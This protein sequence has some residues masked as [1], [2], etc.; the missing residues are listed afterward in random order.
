MAS[1]G[2]GTIETA[3]EAGLVFAFRARCVAIAVVAVVLLIG[4][5]WPRN[6][7]YLSFAAG[8]FAFGYVPFLLRRTR[9]AEAIKLAFVV[10]DVALITAAVLN[11]PAS[12][13]SV[14][15]PIQTR[16]KN[17]NFLLLLVLLGEAAITY[18]A[19]RVAW[20]GASIVAVWGASFA[21]VYGLPDTK[22]FGEITAQRTDEALLDVFLDP[23][24]VSLPSFVTQV[25]ATVFL[26]ALVASA[27]A[28][29][30]R[31][32]VAQVR[33][34]R[35]RSDL[36]RYVSP[37]V[38]EALSRRPS[39]EFGAPANRK[40]A[41]LF[42]DIV[43]FTRFNE[44]LSP[45]RTFALLRGFQD[46][47]TQAV[48]RHGGTLDKYLGDGFMATFGSLGDEPDAAARAIA[49]AFDLLTEVEAWNAERGGGPADRL[50]VAIGLHY[51]TAVVG[52]LGSENRLEFTAVG[53]VVNVASRLEE[54]TRELG[55][56]LAISD[57]CVQ[58]AG[59]LDRPDRLGRTVELRLRGRDAPLRVHVA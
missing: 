32:L 40:V 51:G 45:E 58:A 17:Q 47:S 27:V 38:A 2:S 21:Y 39:A 52:N 16:L 36:A 7:Y 31:H 59:A 33:A 35:L 29:S 56:A 15:W 6:L 11:L 37:D 28:R 19:R 46:R 55:C 13:V 54:A 43:G 14:D 18:S 26:T 20:T 9:H 23:T 42:A 57:A 49:C 10:L 12:P 8:L 5:Q 25:I 34:E 24:Y 50:A 1:A 4:V 30:R 22:R 48:F 53:D 44:R 3:E 41:V